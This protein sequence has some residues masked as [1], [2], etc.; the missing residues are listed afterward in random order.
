MSMYVCTYLLALNSQ[1]HMY[2]DQTGQGIY[3]QRSVNRFKASHARYLQ[4]KYIP[5]KGSK[6][7]KRYKPLITIKL[8]IVINC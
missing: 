3:H 8:Q 2:I 7:T 1:V 5:Q 4:T 6:Q